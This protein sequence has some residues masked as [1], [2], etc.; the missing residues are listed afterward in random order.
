[1]K[2]TVIILGALVLTL[3]LAGG[4]IAGEKCNKVAA[5]SCD[6][7]AETASVASHC[8][9]TAAK[10]AYANKLESSGCEKTAKT[11]YA[12]TMG[13]VAFANALVESSCSTTA[14]KATWAFVQEQTGCSSTATAATKHAVAQAAYDECLT[15][16]GCE[17]TA[18]AKY[19]KTAKVVGAEIAKH[20]A[21]ASEE[22][23]S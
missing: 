18:G 10:A 22:E 2:K 14:A 4:A 3:G 5:K 21:D 16:T 9:S 11:A 7:S 17:K 23:S 13:E 20:M 8:A 6:K 15:E 12:H 1:M 19:E